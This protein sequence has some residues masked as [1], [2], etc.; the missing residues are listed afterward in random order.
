MN[1][2]HIVV[3]TITFIGVMLACFL[4]IGLLVFGT[5][6]TTAFSG[7]ALG[8][9]VVA[10]GVMLYGGRNSAGIFLAVLA[11]LAVIITAILSRRFAIS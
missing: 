7:V 1:R 8:I 2:S 9:S 4:P 6:S 3:T 11:Y 5:G 10:V